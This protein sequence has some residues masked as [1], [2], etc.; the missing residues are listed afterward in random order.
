MEVCCAFSE[1]C[2]IFYSD[3]TSKRQ[4]L[5]YTVKREVLVQISLERNLGSCTNCYC[6]Q[7]LVTFFLKYE[8]TLCF[9]YAVQNIQDKILSY[10]CQYVKI[11]TE[12]EEKIKCTECFAKF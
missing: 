12:K 3:L 4:N 1:M 2:R 9:S 6:L 8:Q 11:A 5:Y 10:L 7:K